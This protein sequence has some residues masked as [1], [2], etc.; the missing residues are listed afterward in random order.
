MEIQYLQVKDIPGFKRKGF[1][2]LIFTVYHLNQRLSYQIF[3][4]YL[5]EQ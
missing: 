5:A 2:W 4:I 3:Y 1:M